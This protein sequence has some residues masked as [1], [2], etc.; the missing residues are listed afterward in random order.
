MNQ[1]I[2]FLEP[3]DVQDLQGFL[4]RAKKLDSDGLVRIKSYGNV[5]AVSVSPIFEASLLGSGPTVIGMRT[6]AVANEPEV[7]L[8]FE[9]SAIL[10][11]LASPL[12]Q[13]TLRL[14]LPSITKRE[15][16]TGVSAPLDSWE[17]VLDLPSA[18][19]ESAAELGIEEVGKALGKS[20]G[21]SIANKVRAEVWGR[22]LSF[23]QMIPAGASFGM[24]GLGFLARESRVQVFRSGAWL[25]L[26][27][28]YGHVL[29]KA[30]V[31]KGV[32]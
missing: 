5:L 10:D 30:L 25:R 24:F 13:I 18:D 17:H 1:I 7:D 2:K 14:E 32:E 21:V 27:T 6:I 29:T 31:L 15:S 12:V 28:P 4:A 9:L 22:P 19:L 8:S 16:W 11:R 26:S 23:A 20:I 3:A